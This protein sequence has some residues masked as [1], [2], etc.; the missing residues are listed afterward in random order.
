MF[1]QLIAIF[2]FAG[3]LFQHLSR[4][5]ILADYSLNKN[6]IAQN[7]CENKNKPA[8]HCNGKCYLA[9]KLQEEEKQ[10]APV[11]QKTIPEIQLFF[12]SSS[13]NIDADFDS[14]TF[15][16]Y[17]WYNMLVTVSYPHTVFHPPGA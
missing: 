12:V 2:F 8:M 4:F 11:S 15:S 5:M 16:S 17:A 3:L 10:R 13:I 6:Y 1:K 14:S 9:K 7:L